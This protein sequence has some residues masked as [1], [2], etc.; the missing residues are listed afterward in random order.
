MV[1][2]GL[3]IHDSAAQYATVELIGQN[4]TIR[5]VG[6]I[7]ELTPESL[8]AIAESHGA[9][10]IA[11][12]LDEP[13]TRISAVSIPDALPKHKIQQYVRSRAINLGFE[14]SDDRRALPE[15]G[16]WVIAAAS[17]SA[18]SRTRSL[19]KAAHLRL[20]RIEHAPTAS[21]RVLPPSAQ[22]VIE[23][24]DDDHLR[25]TLVSPIGFAQVRTIKYE[26]PIM[27]GDNKPLALGREVDKL[28]TDAE[29]KAFI[30][31]GAPLHIGKGVEITTRRQTIPI[32][33]AGH[34]EWLGAA[35][36]I[37]AAVGAVTN[38][39]GTTPCLFVNFAKQ[40]PMDFSRYIDPIVA[41][42]P[43]EKYRIPAVAALAL[44]MVTGVQAGTAWQQQTNTTTINARLKR[45]AVT[46]CLNAVL[47]DADRYTREVDLLTA[48]NAARYSGSS[49]AVTFANMLAAMPR[50]VRMQTMETGTQITF[51]GYARSQKSANAA[52][53]AVGNPT[54]A[55]DSTKTSS[56]VPFTISAPNVV[57]SPNGTPAPAA[58]PT[59]TPIVA[60]GTCD[61]STRAAL[62]AR[63]LP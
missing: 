19:A 32:A 35:A 54:L 51:A 37:G 34:D 57:T 16:A 1:V 7:D 3:S 20:N 63:R 48:Y 27:G 58:T 56:A 25:V 10:T 50:D 13:S 33:I 43:A 11:I 31:A 46:A 49:L 9:R 24:L 5:S 39:R 60:D 22:I 4:V 38:N 29:A 40:P 14:E 47:V 44:L 55:F 12:T 17:A 42:F 28:V 36:A 45:S 2:L 53:T 15:S 6:D 61:P 62:L 8:R 21:I 41:A 52:Y 26:P 59:P 23:K 18:V 30:E